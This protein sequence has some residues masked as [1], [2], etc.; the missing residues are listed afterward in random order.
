MLLIPPPPHLISYFAEAKTKF[1]T[2]NQDLLA[3]LAHFHLVS[4]HNSVNCDDVNVFFKVS[5]IQLPKSYQA[6]FL[7]QVNIYGVYL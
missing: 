2:C 1:L 7:K 6:T 3:H 5:I 4:N